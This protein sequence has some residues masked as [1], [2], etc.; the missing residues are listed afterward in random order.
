MKRTTTALALPATLAL[1]NA[2]SPTQSEE[3]TRAATPAQDGYAWV[4]SDTLVAGVIDAAGTADPIQQATLSTK[5]MGSV[6]AVLVREG[7]VVPAGAVLVRLDARELEARGRQVEAQLGEAEAV[8]REAATHAQR[9]RALFADSAAPRAQLDAAETG[10]ARAEAAVRGAQAGAAELEAVGSY[11]QLRAPFAGTVTRRHV[12]PGAFAAPG[13]PLITLEDGSRLRISASAS[14][15]AVRGLRRGMAVA[16]T[17]EGRPATAVIEGVVPA[18]LGTTYTVNAIVDN[19]DGLYLPHSAAT[20]ALAQ[21]RRPAILVPA[22]AIRRDGDLAGVQLVRAGR[23]ELR[24]VRLGR[25]AGET[26]EV[27][28]G[29]APGDSIF[30]PASL[31]STR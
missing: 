6:T 5:L 12:D 1:L 10:L 17:I 4:V 9:I 11:T 22:A 15:D 2:C 24:W 25:L 18:P 27:V 26:V 30:V 28:A 31:A 19:G 29:L 3:G 13:A 8:R 14:P 21:G 7:D 16:V 20:I 23:T